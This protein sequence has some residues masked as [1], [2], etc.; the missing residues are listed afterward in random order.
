M[1]STL[2]Y[3]CPS[4]SSGLLACSSLPS[5]KKY[6]KVN[7][8]IR[9]E[10]LQLIIQHNMSIKEASQAL[11]INYSSAKAI[12]ASH[13][14]IQIQTHRLTHKNSPQAAYRTIAPLETYME[15]VNELICSTGGKEVSRT[16]GKRKPIHKATLILMGAGKEQDSA[17]NT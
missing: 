7:E 11:N 9:Q 3:P 4:L 8:D 17:G 16:C 5:K 10:F 15:A 1:D 6:S 12:L 14:K 2:A 13:R